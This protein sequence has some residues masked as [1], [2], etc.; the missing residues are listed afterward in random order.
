MKKSCIKIVCYGL[1]C[2]AILVP[3]VICQDQAEAS[4]Y[5]SSTDTDMEVLDYLENRH[6]A[7]RENILLP[8]QEQLMRDA[9]KM[10]EELRNPL[11]PNK[12]VPIALEG[13]DIF[14]NQETG[15][16]EVTGN[17][18]LTTLD[19][20]RFNTDNLKGNLDEATV[21]ID[22]KSKML[23]MTPDQMKVILSG[24][25]TH[26]DYNRSLGKME[27]VIGKAGNKYIRGKRIELYPD[28]TVIYDGSATKCSAKNPDYRMEA[29][30]IELYPDG[31]IIS[32]NVRYYIR[33]V[34]VYHSRKEIT[35]PNAD[36]TPHLPKVGYDSDNG[37]WIKDT[38]RYDIT[39][40]TYVE[41]ELAYFTKQHWK[42]NIELNQ[43]TKSFGHFKLY[44]GYYEDGKN[45]W[46]RK[47]PTL[48]YEYSHRIGHSPFHWRVEYEHG[49]WHQKN[50]D[51]VHDYFK[52]SLATDAIKLGAW[53]LR[54]VVD[55]SVTKESV[56]ASKVTGVGYTL[57]LFRE[58]DDRWAAFAR[59]AYSQINSTNSVFEYNTDSYS[60]KFGIGASYRFTDHDRIAAGY[61]WDADAVKL[62]DI[63]WYWFH[64]MHCA[65]L[66]VRYRPKKN[67][68]S[69]SMQFNPW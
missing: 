43:W 16:V 7:E 58:F 3:Q 19:S 26:Y 30:R 24:Y 5:T 35:D 15:D 61:K 49:Y 29:D 23:Q 1:M 69:V 33:D 57:T 11:D 67:S 50:V 60:R 64:D 10:R 17:V 4:V 27:D 63:D 25:K 45:R 6:R 65:E 66:I 34:K 39:D 22:G 40:T 52:V 46:I 47:G 54:P 18:Q 44:Q 53:S 38:Y 37:F 36:S 55:Y 21:D 41:A 51:S 13:D 31:R 9:Y 28:V 48:K 56:N 2:A 62:E 20:R 32:Y 59:W 68:Y 14:Y 8:E 12:N 42:G